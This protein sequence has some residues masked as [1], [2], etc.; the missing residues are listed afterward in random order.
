MTKTEVET[1]LL[2]KNIPFEP[3]FFS[4]ELDP[5][6][7][8]IFKTLV[9][10]GNK[11]GPVIALIPLN[12]RLDYKKTAQLT[13]NRKIGLPPVEVAFELTGYPHGANTP[14]G[15]FLHSPDYVFLFDEIIYHFKEI[16]ISA[17]ELHKGIIISVDRLV[18]LITPTMA[19]LLQ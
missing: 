2:S 15:I 17:G 3:Y 10:K 9:L 16:A 13:G 4:E 8:P 6:K 7:T 19:D 1:Y 5:A 12:Q 14:I 18:D 11:T